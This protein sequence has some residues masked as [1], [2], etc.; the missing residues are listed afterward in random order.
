MRATMSSSVISVGPGIWNAPK[1]ISTR[2]PPAS[3][4]IVEKA[5]RLP[6]LLAH[7]FDL[8]FGE[9][10]QRVAEFGHETR[11]QILAHRELEPAEELHGGIQK[12]HVRM[13]D[14]APDRRRRG[15]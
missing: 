14:H 9:I 6:A 11:L 5:S 1:P 12:R 15:A 2:R 13:G 10:V 3:A 7:E 8:P 4:V